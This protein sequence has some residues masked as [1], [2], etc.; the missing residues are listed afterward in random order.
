[1]DQI[2]L[3]IPPKAEYIMVVRLTLSGIAARAGFDFETIEDLKMAI[4]EVF[5]LFEIEK[6]KREVFLEF[7]VTDA[8]LDIKIF[9][10]DGEMVDNE[11]AKMIL[12]TL[13]DEAEF[14]RTEEGHRVKIKK[15]H[16]GV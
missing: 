13:I 8:Y 3:T 7:N 5:N 10:P 1:M 9:V 2:M 4:S 15:F 16:R 6:L 14:E 12:Q 11:F